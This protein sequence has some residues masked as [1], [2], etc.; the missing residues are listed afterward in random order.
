MDTTGVSFKR[1]SQRHRLRVRTGLFNRPRLV[2]G[3]E[4]TTF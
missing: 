4:F 3:S 1:S 2:F